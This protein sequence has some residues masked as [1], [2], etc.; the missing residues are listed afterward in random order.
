M[1]LINQLNSTYIM[2]KLFALL[3]MAVFVISAHAQNVS[4]ELKRWHKVTITFDGPNT[5]ESANPNPFLDYRLEVTFTK[6]GLSYKVPGY[7]SGCN[8]PADSGCN[9]GN[10][11]K[12]HFSP[13]ETG[14]WNWKASF[15]K[16]SNVAI[17]GGGSGA[18]FM[19]NKSG[20]F[21]IDESNKSGR[22]H[23]AKNKG[24]LQY[25]GEHYL[26]YSGTSPSNPNGSWFVK[27][28]ADSPENAFNYVDFDATPN[29]KNTL[30]KIG[31]KTWQPHQQDY[32]ASDASSYTW[33][34]GKGT[35]ILG[36]INYLSSQ[37][38][39]VFSFLTWNTSGDGGA[40]FPHTLQ[41]SESQYG[42]TAQKDQWGKVNKTRF[43]VSKLAQWEKVM[44]YADKK[45]MYL[46]LKTMETEND[47]L[48]DGD[49]F[50]NQR[51]VYYRE[52]IARFGH[53]LALNWNLT[54]ETTLTDAV[55]R[56]TA[57]YIKNLDPYDHNIV[58]H[59]YPNQQDQRYDPL[60]G[61]KSVLTGAS[62]Q[63]DKT[64]VH[65]DVRRWLEKS[66]NAGKKWIVAND[67]QGSA[68][69]GVRVS[70]KRIR[71]EVLWGTL[72]AG[73]AGVE[74]YSGYTDNDG[75]INGNDH[76][77][78]GGKY[79]DGGHALAFFN[80]YLQPYMVNMVS[81]DGVTSDGNDYVFAKAGEVYAVYRP[82]GG[83]TNINLQGAN[84]SYKVQWY[85]PRTGGNL[86]AATNAGS[87]LKAPSNDDWVAL[88]TKN[89]A[90][91]PDPDPNPG[92]CGNITFN[93]TSDFSTN[94]SGFSPAYIDAARGAMA[95]NA[96]VHKNK[97][98][99][100]ETTFNGNS[101]TYN[102]RL[103]TLTEVDG[104]SQYRISINGKQIGTYKNPTTNTD[105]TAAGRTFNTIQ[106]NKGQKIRVEFNSVTNGKIP[107]GGGTAF[108][109]GRWTSI[110][111]T[112]T[113]TGTGGGTPGP[114][115]GNCDYDFEEK[116][117]LAVIEVE[118]LDISGTSWSKKTAA[119]GFSG[120]NYLE[121][122]GSDNFNNPGNGVISAK[123]KINSPGKYRFQW[124]N[125]V[126]KGNDATE[127]NDTWLK[128][129]ANDFFGEKNGKKVYPKGA[130]KSPV[131]EGASANG[132]MKVYSNG[133]TAWSWRSSTNDFDPHAVFAQFNSAGVYTIQISGRSKNHLVDR[134]VL[135]KTSISEANATNL[136]RSETL[137]T[138]TPAPTPTP[139]TT[140][141]KVNSV[142]AP[143]S[144]KQGETVSVDVNY[145]A[146]ANSEIVVLFQ[147]DAAPW[148]SYK[149]AR[150]TVNAG[151][152]TK[153]INVAIPSNTPVAND[154]YQFQVFLTSPGGNW[155]SRLA[156]LRK[157]D[158]NVT[159][160]GGTTPPPP[161]P[162]GGPDGYTFATDEGGT[163]N[164]SG[165][166]NIA[167][168]ANGQ[169]EIVKN[170]SS[171][172][173]CN[174]AT[175]GDPIPGVKKACYIQQV[176][177]TNPNPTPPTTGNCSFGAPTSASLPSLDKADYSN[178][179]VLGDGPNLSNLKRFRI[180]WNA[181]TKKVTQFAFNTRNGNPDYYVDLRG[182]IEQN[183]GS[184]NPS[185]SI[186]GS[187]LGI[188]GDYWVTKNG[189]NFAMVSKGR[190]FTIYCST[191]SSSPSCTGQKASEEKIAITLYPNPANDQITISGIEKVKQVVIYDMLGKR[192]KSLNNTDGIN[193]QQISVSDL[194]SGMYFVRAVNFETINETMIK[195]FKK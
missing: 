15:K 191:S 149:E 46:H 148:T 145:E 86:T 150:T 7:F 184:G 115:P 54:E 25:V 45:G 39:N 9:S 168:G 51:K 111:L 33:D 95:I 124:R 88:I 29:Y 172:R 175:F 125:K 75:D 138:A 73:G 38:A 107:E 187:G 162:S 6:G 127:H 71:D 155:A 91:N 131:A 83:T 103:N 59:T 37:G 99:A 82:N 42:K 122:T 12:V 105:Y 121:W 135:Y 62:I 63:T 66:R 44:E 57:S 108:S 64:K 117:G 159:K 35:E 32:N 142:Q 80:N 129:N 27:A 106:I 11:W 194:P 163:V 60:L 20:S 113:G 154:A 94:V 89:G 173:A 85:N 98:A 76:R 104:E 56:S 178:I 180:S 171:N 65:N 8:N 116:D 195:F 5:S 68:G 185:V 156:N 53:H 47:N 84:S 101:G 16:G 1:V 61:N 139:P 22:D 167:Y 96:E 182:N 132:W 189:N 110:Q 118:R 43:D 134:M 17:N 136:S 19:D 26:R 70:D 112:C 160:G 183:F 170:V 69:E 24:M 152:G 123:V 28:G 169:F 13:G 151:K 153:S 18:G 77:K 10:K 133:T 21:D 190:N 177:T 3:L 74:Y 50:G 130:G 174:N 120:A 192:V 128:I 55:A 87:S 36:M 97:F 72:M 181:G 176:S 137:C 92:N 109:R 49:K 143:S 188:D 179:Y 34:G 164:V 14:K 114:T 78:R 157:N 141:N 48:M 158:V 144:V 58:I 40:V 31:S 146:A 2:K 93:A 23:R 193:N 166:V 186:S 4:G 126:G 90:T 52:L 161:P 79:R 147:L 119:S 140:S 165:T 67:E 41:I 100:G 102:I 30:N 81:S